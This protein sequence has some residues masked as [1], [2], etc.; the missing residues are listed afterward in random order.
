MLLIFH[1]T[2][3]TSVWLH[4]KGRRESPLC[5]NVWEWTQT[6]YTCCG[7]ARNFSNTGKRW[8]I[9]YRQFIKPLLTSF[10]GVVDEE[11]FTT[12]NNVAVL[13]LLYIAHKKIALFMA[14]TAYSNDQAVDWTGK[15]DSY[16][17]KCNVSTQTLLPNILNM[18]AIVGHSGLSILPISPLSISTDI[19]L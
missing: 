4:R 5:P 3:R 9:F 14:I 17:R 13:G 7:V 18:A 16:Q 8:P 19:N 6:S 12:P 11:P 10:L 15:C 1:R 2:Y